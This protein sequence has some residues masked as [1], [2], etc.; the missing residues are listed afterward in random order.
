MDSKLTVT[1]DKA[2]IQEAKAIAAKNNTSLSSLIE[3]YLRRITKLEKAGNNE[4]TP[5][6]ASLYG[7]AKLPEGFDEKEFFADFLLEKHHL[8]NA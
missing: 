6:V 2:L 7:V 1:I 8:K 5:L 4:L 3:N